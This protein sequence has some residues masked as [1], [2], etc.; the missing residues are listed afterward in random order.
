MKTIDC[1]G[2]S[3]PAPVLAT[4]KGLEESPG[5]ICVL[6]DD[7]APRENVGRF[8]R[9]RGYQVTEAPDADGWSLLLTG[10]ADADLQSA[11]ELSSQNVTGER[12]LLITSDRL[13]DG[14]DELG[15]LLM[16]NFLFTLLE[17]TIKPKRI[18]LLNSGVLLA[19]EGSETVEALTKLENHGVELLSCGVCLDYL[20]RKNQLAAGRVT[21][22]FS[23]AE[24]LLAASSVIKL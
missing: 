7:G 1:R 23:V 18:L 10:S 3:C 21:N 11:R 6:V 5:G 16:K 15:R 17:T 8:A 14:P 24:Q 9:N 20:H 19:T 12:V 22:M 13:G 2:Q 4:K